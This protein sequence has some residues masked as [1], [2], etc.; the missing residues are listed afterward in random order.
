MAFGIG[1]CRVGGSKP[2]V[3]RPYV[4]EIPKASIRHHRI[5]STDAPCRKSRVPSGTAAY[6]SLKDLERWDPKIMVSVRTGTRPLH[7]Q[8]HFR[9]DGD[10]AIVPRGL[11][12]RCIL[13]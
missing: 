3:L 11:G 4:A 6:G 10:P 9:L 12:G 1:G 8:L 13:G 7:Y 2:Y 5:L